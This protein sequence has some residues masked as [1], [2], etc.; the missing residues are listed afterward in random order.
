MIDENTTH[1]TTLVLF[2][3]TNR[4]YAFTEWKQAGKRFIRIVDNEREKSA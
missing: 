1:A 3:I 4:P 2:L